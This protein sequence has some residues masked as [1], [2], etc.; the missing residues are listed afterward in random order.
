MEKLVIRR[1]QESD[2][3]RVGNICA[4]I[5]QTPVAK[6]FVQMLT[7]Q[8]LKKED[9]SFVAEL[10][11]EVIGY[12]ISTIMSGIFGIK[13]SAWLSTMGVAPAYM[14]QG[15]GEKLAQETFRMAR[16]AGLQDIYTSVQWDSPDLLS[17]FKTM[18]FDRSKFINLIKRF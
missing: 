6:D 1:L 7:E 12:M 14:G 8:P 5:T 3:T 16:E 2:A 17:Y 18:G 9:L 4:D 15:I 11:G 10:D 13:R